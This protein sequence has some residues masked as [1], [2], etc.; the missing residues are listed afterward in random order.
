MAGYVIAVPALVHGVRLN[1]G[2]K[3]FQW[4]FEKLPFL[5]S[6]HFSPFRLKETFFFQL[7]ISRSNIAYLCPN[8]E[9]IGEAVQK[10]YLE[11]PPSSKPSGAIHCNIIAAR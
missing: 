6:L 8:M 3:Q 1:P 11:R 7:Y 2:G 4:L 5:I 10:S 9:K